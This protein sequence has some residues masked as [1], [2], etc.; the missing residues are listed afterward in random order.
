MNHYLECLLEG[1]DLHYRRLNLCNLTRV[2]G[3]PFRWKYQVLDEFGEAFIF[4]DPSKAVDK[5][6]ELKKRMK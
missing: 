4:D 2:R 5:F 3:F 6:V 1:V